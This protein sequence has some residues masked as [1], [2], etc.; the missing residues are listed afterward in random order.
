VDSYEVTV[1]GGG[2]VGAALAYGLA[3]KGLRTLVLDEGDVA[4]RA[5]RASYGYI[6]VRGKGLGRPEYARWSLL[7]AD[8]WEDLAAELKDV[9]GIDVG[10]E[11]RGSV[12]INLTEEE[13]AASRFLLAEIDRGTGDIGVGN[14]FLD[15]PALAELLPGLGPGVISGCYTATDGHVNP[16]LMLRALHAGHAANGGDYRPDSKVTAIEKGADGF[17]IETRAATFETAKVVIAAG[18]GTAGLADGLGLKTPVAPFPCQIMVTERIQP[19]FDIPTNLVRQ[20]KEGNLLLAF[21]DMLK[22]DDLW[23][24]IGDAEGSDPDTF[25]RPDMS[26][27]VAGRCRKA[28]PF[29]GDLRLVRMWSALKVIAPDGFPIYDE[30]PS[31]PGAYVATAHSGVTLAAAHAVRLPDWIAGGPLP[32]DL[33]CFRSERFNV[34]EAA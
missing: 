20:T 27:I 33:V 7:S 13:D 8:L 32:P 15:P 16:L 19:L 5:A 30:S 12:A 6:L 18:M 11:R 26:R 9:T 31:C 14:E 4:L 24:Q 22:E 1:I 25:T 21:G 29:L 28:F 10:L 34:Q 3:R 23:R 17:R 2:L